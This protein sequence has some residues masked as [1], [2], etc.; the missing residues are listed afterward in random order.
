MEN[1]AFVS[2][3]KESSTSGKREDT[4]K[5]RDRIAAPHGLSHH[6]R[7]LLTEGL[8]HMRERGPCVFLSV[9]AG[10]EPGSEKVV[11]SLVRRLRSDI[12]LRQRRARMRRVISVTV[13]EALGRD[14][15]PKFGAH[16]GSSWN[17]FQ[18]VR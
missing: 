15:Q 2:R 13:F 9:E 12:A 4:S 8:D 6:E 11:R 3:T 14:K 5:V 10:R 18:I 17:L 1:V 7:D 16:M